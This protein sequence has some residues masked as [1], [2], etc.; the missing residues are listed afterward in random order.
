MRALPNRGDFRFR[1][2]LAI[3]RKYQKTS[4]LSPGFRLG[5][6]EA[7][8]YKRV[9][10]GDAQARVAVPRKKMEIRKSKL[11]IRKAAKTGTIYRAPTRKRHR[12]KDRPLQRRVAGRMPALRRRAQHAVPLHARRVSVGAGEV[13]VDDAPVPALPG[14]NVR[15]APVNL[16]AAAKLNRPVKR[17]NGSAAVHGHV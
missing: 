7:R 2:G 4:R 6:A 14:K 16:M 8:P 3:A 17:G 13:F 12:S 10:R 11:E 5:R 9:E 1:F 15:A